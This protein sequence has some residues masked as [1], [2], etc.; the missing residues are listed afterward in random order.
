MSHTSLQPAALSGAALLIVY[1][2]TVVA[3]ALVFPRADWDMLAYVALAL[4]PLGLDFAATHAQTFE[5]VR[6]ATSDG[7][8]LILTEDRP[9][10]I[11]Q[12]ADAE[13]FASMLGFYRVKLLYIEAVRFLSGWFDPVD[14]LRLVSAASAAL[15]GGITLIWLASQRIVAYAPLAIV[16]LMLCGFGAVAR[17]TTPDLFSAVFLVAGVLLYLG[18]RDM[19]A[20]VLLFLA[21]LVRPDHLALVGV[22][23]VISMA[24]RP[25]SWG[26]VA[27]FFVGLVV[28]I[29]LARAAGHPGWWIQLYFSCVE[30]VPTLVG[31]DPPF[32]LTTYVGALVRGVV[33]SAV[34]QRWLPVLL[35]MVFLMVLMLRWSYEF[36]RR[37][38][39]VLTSV[40]VAIPAKFVLLPLHEDRL[41]FAYLVILGLVLVGVFA[42]QTVPIF[43][44]E[45]APGAS[46][47]R[48]R[49]NAAPGVSVAH[50][51]ERTAEP[52]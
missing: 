20:G 44:S 52:G 12:Y 41:F 46:E 48:S 2:A 6:Q 47:A 4:E 43:A 32:S 24:I 8:F 19:F 50:P 22:L 35:M 42:R 45:H 26:A 27:A 10:R 1:T 14:A 30:F 49:V 51:A 36:T 33:R 38:A 40:L 11:R 29:F 13:A 9:Y 17:A 21:V 15:L 16:M 23:M 5:T 31:F 37:E 3:V 39:V 7:E 25:L 18:G 28:Y 34:E